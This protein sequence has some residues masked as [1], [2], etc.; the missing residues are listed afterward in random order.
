MSDLPTPLPQESVL[1]AIGEL[2]ALLAGRS[3]GSDLHQ[4]AFDQLYEELKQYKEDFLYQA[5]K[6]LLLDLLLFFDSLLWFQQNL[7]G[8]DVSPEAMAEGIQYLLDEFLEILYRR[9]VSL[10]ECPTQ[11]DRTIQ[12]AVK[13]LPTQDADQDNLVGQVLKRGFRRGKHVLRPEEVVV[14]RRE[15]TRDPSTPPGTSSP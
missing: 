6:P 12:K 2:K 3:E 4:K 8:K 14:W 9:D 13:V 5:E 10:M 11:F 7:A 1:S 15:G